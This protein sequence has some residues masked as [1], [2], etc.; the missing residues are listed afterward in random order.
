MSKVIITGGLGVLGTAVAHASAR[1][2]HEVALI[3]RALTPSDCAWVCIGG[4]DLTDADA[5]ETAFGLARVALKGADVL[6]NIAGGFTFETVSGSSAAWQEMFAANL[7]TCVNMCRAAAKGLSDDGAIVTVAAAAAETAGAGM[8]PYAASKA[9]VARLTESL[10]AELSG[11]VRVNA[12]LPLILDTPQNRA[13][14]PGI[15][16]QTWTAP[17]AVAD[18]IIFLASPAA[19]AINGV[20]LHVT[21]PSP[22]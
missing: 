9:G 4:V 8:G 6:V 21:A 2:G 11:R 13:D 10:A 16:P 19:R 17:A 5:A 15:D 18:A 1:A 3:D 12:V 20:L 7:L 22:H 14:M